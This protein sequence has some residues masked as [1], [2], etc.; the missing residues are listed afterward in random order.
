MSHSDSK[1]L[2]QARA[3]DRKALTA[4]SHPHQLPPQQNH[5]HKNFARFKLLPSANQ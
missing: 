5:T 2:Q 3:F 1:L 4:V